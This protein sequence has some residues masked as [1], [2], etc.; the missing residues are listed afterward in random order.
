MNPR[1]QNILPHFVQ[2][3]RDMKRAQK[4]R[5]SWSQWARYALMGTKALI[6]LVCISFICWG[7]MQSSTSFTIFCHTKMF[8][9]FSY[10]ISSLVIKYMLAQTATSITIDEEELFTY[11]SVTVCMPFKGNKTHIALKIEEAALASNKTAESLTSDEVTEII[12]SYT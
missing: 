8:S 10:S 5:P 11:P 7:W 2:T 4:T 3:Q 6:I 1:R 12:N 9:I